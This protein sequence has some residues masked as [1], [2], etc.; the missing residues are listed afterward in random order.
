VLRNSG[1]HLLFILPKSSFGR[2]KLS[3]ELVLSWTDRTSCD[4]HLVSWADRSS[5]YHH[6]MSTNT[7][8]YHGS[9]AR[10]FNTD[11]AMVFPRDTSSCDHHVVS[12]TYRS[13]CYH[14]LVTRS[15]ELDRQMSTNTPECTT[16]THTHTDPLERATSQLI[17]LL[18]DTLAH[19]Q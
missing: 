5:C 11:G 15:C 2:D 6:E 18:M 8:A 13:S 3:C 12:W 4:H 17:M 10:S 14:H 1:F 16:G 9:H 19:H 7:P